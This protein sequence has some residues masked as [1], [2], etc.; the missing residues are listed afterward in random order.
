MNQIKV[1]NDRSLNNSGKNI[2]F[3]NFTSSGSIAG[4]DSSLATAFPE[5]WMFD[6]IIYNFIRIEIKEVENEKQQISESNIS[7]LKLS[8]S[9]FGFWDNDLDSRYDLL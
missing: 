8:E 1:E 3:S 7:W 9:S 5:T 4:F 6:P 2:T